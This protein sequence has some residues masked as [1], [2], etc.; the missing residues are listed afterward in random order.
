VWFNNLIALLTGDGWNNGDVD[1]WSDVEDQ[2]TF[3]IGD[4][5]ARKTY[6]HPFVV[7]PRSPGF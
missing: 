6:F 7:K 3:G 5:L 1:E 2:S 4:F